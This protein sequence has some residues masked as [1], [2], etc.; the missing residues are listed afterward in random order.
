[1]L[2]EAIAARDGIGFVEFAGTH[3][4]NYSALLFKQLVAHH[5]VVDHHADDSLSRDPDDRLGRLA[6]ICVWAGKTLPDGGNG[7]ITRGEAWQFAR[8]LSDLRF[9][10]ALPDW[11]KPRGRQRQSPMATKYRALAVSWVIALEPFLTQ[12]GLAQDEVATAFG[13]A[14]RRPLD[15][16]E[17]EIRSVEAFASQLWAASFGN[18]GP[19]GKCAYLLDGLDNKEGNILVTPDD[20][21]PALKRH[22]EAYQKF[23]KAKA[24]NP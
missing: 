3:L 8:E 18:E 1:M 10:S 2:D 9:A 16:W 7:N 24:K 20:Y 12:K 13:L 4:L 14:D 11:L 19:G 21:Q 17:N 22:G 6:S 5:G 15:D 23:T